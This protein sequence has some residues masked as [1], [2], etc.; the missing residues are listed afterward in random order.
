[1]TQFNICVGIYTIQWYLCNMTILGV[2]VLRLLELV[3][4]IC[5]SKLLTLKILKQGR[6]SIATP[7]IDQPKLYV[8]LSYPLA[9]QYFL[10][11]FHFE[12]K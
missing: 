1:M 7:G 11:Y 9:S 5:K 4:L 6:L 10:R 3:G 12:K 2:K 8:S